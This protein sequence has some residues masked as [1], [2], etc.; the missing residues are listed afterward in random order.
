LHSHELS[1]ANYR[2]LFGSQLTHWFGSLA[3]KHKAQVKSQ[4]L[5]GVQEPL[6]S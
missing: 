4:G 3:T 6:T 5:I 1:M 2:L